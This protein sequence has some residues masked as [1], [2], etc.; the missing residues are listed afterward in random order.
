MG[1]CFDQGPRFGALRGAWGPGKSNCAEVA[2]SGNEKVPVFDGRATSFWDYEQQVYLCMRATKPGLVA[3]ASLVILH[4]QPAP[5][6]VCLAEGCGLLARRD[7]ATQIL[8][9]LRNYSAPET[10]NA[11]HQHA[12]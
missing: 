11:I 3:R 6:Q 5:R 9:I 10:A 12:M 1:A 2:A 8:D 7:G 4:M